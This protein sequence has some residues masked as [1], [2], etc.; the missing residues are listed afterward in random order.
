[1][2]RADYESVIAPKPIVEK[3]ERF[4]EEEGYPSRSQA[5]A[6]IVNEVEKTKTLS[7]SLK[8]LFE[9]LKEQI[10]KLNTQAHDKAIVATIDALLMAITNILKISTAPTSAQ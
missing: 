5:L 2:A 3:I 1:M 7:D 8:V 9:Q 4:K 10:S 6:A